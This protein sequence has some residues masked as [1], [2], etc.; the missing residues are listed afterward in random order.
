MLVILISLVTIGVCTFCAA[1][2]VAAFYILWEGNHMNKRPNG[3]SVLLLFA[4]LLLLGVYLPIQAQAAT[5]GDLVYSVSSNGKVTITGC[6]PYTYEKVVIPYSIDGYP[7]TGIGDSAFSGYTGLT[8]VTIPD[9]ITRIGDSAFRGCSGLTSVTIPDSV[10]RIGT[11]AFSDCSSL[12]SVTIGDSVTSIGYSAF[13]D[14]SS[15]TGIWVDNNNAYYGSDDKGVLYSK[16]KTI[17]IQAPATLSGCYTIPDSVT[18]IGDDAFCSCDS[19]TSVTIGDSVTSIG[20]SAFLECYSLSDVYITDLTAWCNINFDGFASN[21]MCRADNLYLNNILLTELVIPEDVTSIGD[22]ALYNCTSLTSVTIG[23]S[24]TSIG[25]SA[26]YNCTSLTSVTIGD[27]VTSIGAS[28]FD[29]CT[30][31]T[32]VIIPDSVTIIGGSAFE[33]CTGLTSVTIGD[34]VTIIGSSAFENCTGLT[35]VI[36]GSNVDRIQSC[37]FSDCSALTSVIIPDSVTSIGSSA[38]SG[39]TGLKEITLP[40]VGYSSNTDPEE[41]TYQY[42]LGYIFGSHSYTGGIITSQY[43]YDSSTESGTITDYYIPAG[44]TAVTITGGELICGAFYNCNILTSVTIGDSVTNIGDCAF[45]NCTSLTSVTIGDSVTSIGYNAFENCSGLTSLTIPDSVTDIGD[46][47]FYNC[48]S[49]TSVT[50]GDSVTSI[51]YSAF[52]N[53]TSLTSVTIGDSVTSIGYNTFENCTSLTSVTIGDSVTSIGY[54]TFENCTSLTSVTIGDSVTS[55]GYNTFENCTSLTSVIIPDSVTRIG[56]SAFYNCTNLTSMIIPDSVTRIGDSAFYNCT[57][58]TSMIIPDSVTIIGDSAFE[59]CTG[60]TS[61]TIGDSVTNIGGSAFENC[62]GLTS[63]TIGDSVTI[64]GGSAFENCTGLTSVTIPDSV[65]NIGSSAFS[66]CTGLKEITLPFVGNRR[67]TVSDTYQYPFGYIFGTD[68]YTGGNSTTQYYYGSNTYSTT[69]TDYYIPAS[70]TTVTITGGEITHGAF[71]NCVGLTSVIIGNGVT[72]IRKSAFGCCTSL[73]CITIGNSLTSIED[74]AFTFCTSLTD[75]YTTDIYSWWEI[76]FSGFSSNPVDNA[77]N[78]HIL[79]ENGAEVTEFVVDSGITTIPDEGFFKCTSLTS[80]TIPDSVTSV[81]SSAFSK[82]KNMI[83]VIIGNSVISIGDKAFDSCDNLA[84]VKIPDSVTSIG[85]NAFSKCKKMASVTIGD[86][87]TS[88][89]YN[90]FENCTSLTS[91][92][93]GDSVKSI[94]KWAFYGCASLSMVNIP[95]SVTGIGNGAFAC[96]YSLTS[97]TIGDSVTSIGE[98]VFYGC[99]SLTSVKIPDG[100]TSI[101][102]SMF[103]YCDSLTSVTIPDSVTSIG[104]YAFYNCDS[105]IDVYYAGTEEKWNNIS[106]GHYNDDL[107]DATIHHNHIHDYSVIKPVVIAATCTKDGYI[108]Y[109]CAYGETYSQIIPVL[110]HDFSNP[111]ETSQ[112]TC[113]QEGHTGP[114]CSRCDAIRPDTVVDALGHSIVAVP[115]LD[116]TCTKD[117]HGIGTRCQRCE[118]YMKTPE[119]KPALGHKYGKW[120]VLKEATATATGSKQRVCSRCGKKETAV[121]PKTPVINTQPANRYLSAGKTAKFTVK[122]TGTGLKYQWQYRT[123]FTGSWKNA[124]ATGSK[125]ATVSVPATATRNGYQYRC[126]ITDQE[127]RSIYS[128]AAT[129]KIVTLKV[130][131][132]PSDKYLPA[133][134]TARFT[135]KVTGTGLKYQWQYRTAAKGSWKN[136]SATGSKTATVSVPATATRNG[137]QYRC[138]ITDKYGNVIYSNAATLKIVTLKITTQPSSITLAKGKTATF[139]VVARGT[140]LKYQWQYRT[141]AKGSWKKASATGNKTATLKVPVTAAKNGYQYRCVITDKYNNVITS[142]AAILKV[143]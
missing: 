55:I 27:S 109:T 65:T 83:S 1:A 64:I 86:S 113:D 2:S 110:G 112:P 6:R 21:P 130:T 90:T 139:K 129:L 11:Y 16:G 131:T 54:N 140:E 135:V 79:D 9:S 51:G 125:T 106:I 88:I 76:S 103:Y 46:C 134:K 101:K 10:T 99:D 8:S 123:S 82:C 89:G 23:D 94:E 41:D 127:G 61:V 136:A 15:L 20:G 38:F 122:A 66:G 47:A 25:F 115:A 5:Y 53:C 124:S 137:Y 30:N 32:S 80:V 40:F 132:Q 78:M 118:K 142:K 22:H 19:L 81:G 3:L 50:I 126:K 87:V 14:C 93:I 128:N 138:K 34:S 74:S 141:S 44:L 143:K 97:V 75:V 18:S 37:A 100:I 107:K 67:N 114:G 36:I 104:A 70:L 96:C 108:E 45:Y 120:T 28:A 43:Y 12:T 33:N 59:N 24:V 13:S 102:N 57:N 29:N 62:T 119:V 117:G 92:A 63:A 73:T 56:D 121:I 111:V 4:I 85:S 84:S 72:A 42:P 68:S 105:L 60:L 71:Y 91:V 31:L 58:L 39:C 7:V 133:G 116:P 98:N 17:L 48:A 49:L 35:S 52:E 26:F 95:D 69:E 77:C